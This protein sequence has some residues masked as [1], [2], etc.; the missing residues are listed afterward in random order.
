M[1]L[2]VVMPLVN[3]VALKGLLIKITWKISPPYSF[4]FPLLPVLTDG[5]IAHALD[6]LGQKT[7]R[8]NMLSTVSL[9]S[10]W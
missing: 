5:S 1:V 9:Y 4:L 8:I 3:L 2:D 7:Q 6:V 10:F